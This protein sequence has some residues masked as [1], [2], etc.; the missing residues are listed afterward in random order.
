MSFVQPDLFDGRPIPKIGG[1]TFDPQKDGARLAKQ[2]TAVRELML[3]G[4]ARTLFEIS[5]LVGAPVQSV[6]ARV[7]DLRKN[8]GGSHIIERK[9]ISDGT[10]TYRMVS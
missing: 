8:S 9:R 6:S 10:W 4:K 2:F 3:D 1:K 7:R 5:E